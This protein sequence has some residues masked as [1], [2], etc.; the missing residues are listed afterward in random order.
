MSLYVIVICQ[1]E[2]FA[3][4]LNVPLRKKRPDIS[5]EAG[6]VVHCALLALPAIGLRLGLKIERAVSDVDCCRRRS[7]RGAYFPARDYERTIADLAVWRLL[8]DKPTILR[9][10]L[11]VA[12]SV[13]AESG[14]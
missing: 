10:N 7:R 13:R 4:P 11:E 12:Y 2:R 5:F 8:E 14:R 9:Q 6:Q 1:V 3:H